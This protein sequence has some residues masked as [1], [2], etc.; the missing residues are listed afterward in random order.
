M[1]SL[2]SAPLKSA[3]PWLGMALLVPLLTTACATSGSTGSQR[4]LYAVRGTPPQVRLEQLAHSTLARLEPPPA[5]TRGPDQTGAAATARTSHAEAPLRLTE[6]FDLAAQADQRLLERQAEVAEARARLR[7]VLGM[8][9]PELKVGKKA[10]EQ[11]LYPGQTWELDAVISPPRPALLLA[12]AA[13]A[14]ARL[15]TAQTRLA[16]RKREL[17]D[18]LRSRLDTVRIYALEREAAQETLAAQDRLLTLAQER[19]RL[20]LTTQLDVIL[21]EQQRAE[22]AYELAEL[23]ASLHRVEGDF[24]MLLGPG[25]P[26]RPLDLD[27]PGLPPLLVMQD[28]AQPPAGT[29]K[30]T[31]GRSGLETTL[32]LTLRPLPS[33]E[34]LVAAAFRNNPGLHDA[35]TALG[36]AEAEHRQ[37]LVSLLPSVKYIQLGYTLTPIPYSVGYS[38]WSVS[39]GVEVPIPGFNT[40]KTHQA[41]A[42]VAVARA[43][44]NTE[45]QGVVRQLEGLRREAEAAA[46]TWLAFQ[47]GPVRLAVKAEA[48]VQR[49]LEA[50]RMD[51]LQ[52]ALIEERNARVSLKR[53]QLL[54]AYVKAVSELRTAVG[55]TLPGWEEDLLAPQASAP[56]A[57]APPGSATPEK[58]GTP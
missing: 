47:A 13:V 41:G 2:M 52:A 12:D 57:F 6:A 43:A 18:E 23:T 38:P 37:A 25:Q 55:G 1:A 39:A 51:L 8:D 10:F 34:A 21:T 17:L 40:L 11:L 42:S 9:S 4:V 15:E 44:L 24:R 16:S 19:L 35:A 54:R 14:R 48:E 32:D 28:S 3:T 29:G 50:G 56:P 46:Q 53:V 45:A 31:D 36:E 27:D 7:D 49:A 20:N 58:G 5:D 30:P 26:E 22:V 33:S